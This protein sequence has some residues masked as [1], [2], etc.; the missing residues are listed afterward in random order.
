VVEW[1]DW[2]ALWCGNPLYLSVSPV[3]MWWQATPPDAL[4]EFRKP[5]GHT[6]AEAGAGPDGTEFTET[7][8]YVRVAITPPLDII[9]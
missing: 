7:V 4:S 9:G 6:P 1:P 2:P 5:S 3:E 8:K